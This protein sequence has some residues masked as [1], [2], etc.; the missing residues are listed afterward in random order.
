MN[1]IRVKTINPIRSSAM[2][3]MIR[4][5]STNSKLMKATA[6]YKKELRSTYMSLAGLSIILQRN[7]LKLKIWIGYL[8][9]TVMLTK[10]RCYFRKC[11]ILLLLIS[12]KLVMNTKQNEPSGGMSPPKVKI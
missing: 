3:G 2:W 5:G 10:Y 1:I 6:R 4:K 12:L 11:A 7:Q 9:N 8:Q